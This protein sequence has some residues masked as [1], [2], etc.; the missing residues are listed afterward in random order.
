MTADPNAPDP[1]PRPVEQQLTND[2]IIAIFGADLDDSVMREQILQ[3]LVFQRKLSICVDRKAKIE[4]DADNAWVA[5][6][7]KRYGTDE[8]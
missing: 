5:A 4:R 2:Q 6:Y 1:G 8:G 3:N 7:V